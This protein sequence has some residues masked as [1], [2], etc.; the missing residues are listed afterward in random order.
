MNEIPCAPQVG[1]EYLPRCAPIS[2]TL[3]YSQ[4]CLCLR[5]NNRASEIRDQKWLAARGA[6]EQLRVALFDRVLATDQAV[7]DAELPL[8]ADRSAAGLAELF[9]GRFA[10][11][12]EPEFPAQS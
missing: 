7:Q 1:D 9:A 12:R 11:T 5:Q 8:L 10:E 6:A 3:P 2:A 4:T